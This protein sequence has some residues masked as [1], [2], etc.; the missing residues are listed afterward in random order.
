MYYRGKK[1]NTRLRERREV[2]LDLCSIRLL[3]GMDTSSLI[4]TIR[5]REH[6]H[7]THSRPASVSFR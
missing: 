6:I 3:L 2:G 4:R 5:I 7:R 1:N